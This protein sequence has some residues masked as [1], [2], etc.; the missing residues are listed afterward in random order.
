MECEG[1]ALRG[2]NYFELEN[3][4]C[5]SAQEEYTDLPCR[6]VI[7]LMILN[8]GHTKA[9]FVEPNRDAIEM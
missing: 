5:F 3:S 7:I 1:C 4:E 9:P 8:T 6:R 2:R